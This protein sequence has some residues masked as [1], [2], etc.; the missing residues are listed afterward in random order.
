MRQERI[1]DADGCYQK[2]VAGNVLLH[3]EAAQV[4]TMVVKR[5]LDNTASDGAPIRVLDLACGGYPVTIAQIMAN[6]PRRRFHY[7]GIDINYDQLERIRRF[8]FPAN[9]APTIAEGDSWAVDQLTP[10]E[11]FDLIFIGLNTHHATPEELAFAAH[12]WFRLCAPRGL[13][14]NHDL[15]RPTRFPYLRRPDIAPRDPDKALRLIDPHKLG[16]I[17]IP[18]VEESAMDWRDAFITIDAGLNRDAGIGEVDVQAILEHIRE[19]DYPVST[20]EMR[21]I[22]TQVGFTVQIHNFNGTSHPLREYLAL[23]EGQKL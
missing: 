9:V 6:I 16:E 4:G 15:F 13:L 19:R 17:V 1:F 10:N 20:E 18:S 14:L 11:Q 12:H 2:T 3:C 7:T 21:A 22:L 5:W 8:A 23:I